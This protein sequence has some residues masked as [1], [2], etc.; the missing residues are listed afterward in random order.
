MFSSNSFGALAM[1]DAPPPAAAPAGNG[2]V[3]T[4][5]LEGEDVD[6]EVRHH[7]GNVS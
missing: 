6:A 7:L 3:D 2:G 1:D 4:R 5:L